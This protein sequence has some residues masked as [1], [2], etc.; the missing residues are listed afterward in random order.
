MNKAQMDTIKQQAV[1]RGL[2]EAMNSQIWK[3]KYILEEAM[4]DPLKEYPNFSTKIKQA[5]SLIADAE[6][7]YE[8]L[9][10]QG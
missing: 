7:L 8:D 2:K 3:A 6:Q 9:K 5:K 10:N 4:F 1:A